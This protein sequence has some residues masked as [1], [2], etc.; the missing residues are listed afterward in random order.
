MT[1]AASGPVWETHLWRRLVDGDERALEELYDQYAS[2]VFGLAYRV[3]GDSRL[4]EDIT[5]EVLASAWSQPAD[6]EPGAMPLRAYLS[7]KAHE[8]AA[9]R[10]R[11]G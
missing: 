8:I 9:D 3:T 4:A 2:H 11:A 5:V 10:L 1:T 7:L 6:F